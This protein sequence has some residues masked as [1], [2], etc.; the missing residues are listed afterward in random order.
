MTSIDNESNAGGG[1]GA[2][3]AGGDVD[4]I[5]DRN[6]LQLSALLD[7]ELPLDEAR[8]LLRRL[9]HDAELGGCWERWRVCGDV[10]RGQTGA[11]LPGGFAGRVAAAVASE[12]CGV[13]ATSTGAHRWMRWG[14]SAALAASVAVIALLLVRQSPDAKAPV[15]P[16]TQ[17]AATT[18]APAA[19]D[20]SVATALAPPA[21]DRLPDQST[22]LVAAIAVAEVPRRVATRRSRGQSQRA[23]KRSPMRSAVEAPAVA[24][25]SGAGPSIDPFS[26]VNMPGSTLPNRP[27]PRALLPGAHS[28]GAFTVDYGHQ[29]GSS[30]SFYPFAP[31]TV[32]VVPAEDSSGR[33]EV[34]H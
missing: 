14:G 33:D 27:W 12:R 7:G 29:G 3:H 23:A 18:P 20:P 17:I 28:G 15:A 26:N 30:P 25:A 4:K 34:P 13:A 31:R 24:A 32:P 22:P 1:Q 11:I 10:L 19:A 8:F 16:A 5:L 2:A 6:R 9:E 21:P